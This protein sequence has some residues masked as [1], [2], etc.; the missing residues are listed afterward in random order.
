MILCRNVMIYFDRDSRRK[1]VRLLEESLNPGGYLLIGHAEL[2]S[3]DETELESVY[4]AV[5]RKKKQPA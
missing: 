2:L 3:A 1:L 4:P 5:Y